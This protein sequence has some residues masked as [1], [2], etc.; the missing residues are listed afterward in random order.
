MKSGTANIKF[1]IDNNSKAVQF[2]LEE[3]E[4][5]EVFIHTFVGA[6]EPSETSGVGSNWTCTCS[7]SYNQS[8]VLKSNCS[9]SC[10]CKL[11]MP[12]IFLIAISSWS[13][14]LLSA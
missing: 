3:K 9:S 6:E 7:S 1:Y 11:G 5:I 12:L 14:E 8:S 4:V 10:D 13:L 2:F